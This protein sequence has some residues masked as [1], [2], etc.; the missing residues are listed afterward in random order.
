MSN[1]SPKV[2]EAI[3]QIL[4]SFKDGSALK[5]VK[6]SLNPSFDVPCLKY[7]RL[8]RFIIMLHGT[9]DARG[10]DM[11]RKVG[12]YVKKGSSAF[13]ILA[14]KIQKFKEENEDGT[15][16]EKDRLIGFLGVPLFRAEDTEGKALDYENLPLPSFKFLDVAQEWGIKVSN[17]GYLGEGFMGC[18]N[19]ATKEITMLS[20]NEKVFLHE[21]SHA[22]HDRTGRLTKRTK[23]QKEV[24]AEFC[25]C[26]LAQM[27]G[28]DAQI[29]NTYNYLKHYT[30]EGK[31][32]NSVLKMIDDIYQVLELI[33]NTNKTIQERTQ[34]ITIQEAVRT[35]QEVTQ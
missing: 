34:I 2:K 6:D 32:E 23:E 29:G 1:H 35:A 16:E 28:R 5:I 26:V 10:F 33:L 19:R 8:N 11:W 13:Y 15:T 7:S 17:Q 4:N 24:V 25:A 3:E 27:L 18:Y 22:S 12:R 9:G 30:G 31:I 20:P 21:L 14:P